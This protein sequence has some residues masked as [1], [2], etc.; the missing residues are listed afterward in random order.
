[1]FA[2][3]HPDTVFVEIGANDGE[4]HDHLAPYVRSR[5]WRGVMV[6]PVPFVFERLRENYGDLDRVALE[7]AAVADRD[8]RLP[9]YAPREADASEGDLPPWYP[10]IG[11]F[12]REVALRLAR[13]APGIEER[14]ERIEVPCLTFES[15]CRKHGIGHV[16]L[17]VID[18]EGYDWEILRRLDLHAH[19]PRLVV[20]EHYHLTDA[21]QG[22]A[23]A[24]L[25]SFGYETMA[26]FFDTF[27]LDTRVED[28]L[29]RAWRQLHPRVPAVSIHHGG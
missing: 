22:D 19:R 17:L 16:D 9:F 12:S 11:S 29:T 24:H 27:C 10:A 25:A 23:R 26:E 8:G 6:E 5:N 28:Q 1:V 15:L 13:E 3:T 2:D 20:Y 14:I 7:N 21:E 4:A 18:T